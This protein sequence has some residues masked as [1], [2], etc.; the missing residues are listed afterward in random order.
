[1]MWIFLKMWISRNWDDYNWPSDDRIRGPDEHFG[2]R[3]RWWWCNCSCQAWQCFWAR[4]S[5]LFICSSGLWNLLRLVSKNSVW[6]REVHE[7]VHTCI[8]RAR[9]NMTGRIGHTP[10]SRNTNWY[11]SRH[12]IRNNYRSNPGNTGHGGDKENFQNNIK[13]QTCSLCRLSGHRINRCIRLTVWNKAPMVKNHAK[14][15]FFV[16]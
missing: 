8:T 2:L 12:E 14:L 10:N 1:M 15:I 7:N 16:C 13:S 9:K 5:Y 3:Q 11:K 6:F 4:A